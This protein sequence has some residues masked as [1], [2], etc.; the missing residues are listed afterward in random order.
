[1]SFA[2]NLKLLRTDAGLTQEELAKRIGVSQKTVS[3]W[4]TG[5][6]D[7]VM[8]DIV[9]ICKVLDCPMEKLSDTKTRDIGDVSFE[10]ILVRMRTLTISQLA[11]VLHYAAELSDQRLKLHEM[12]MMKDAYEKQI[13]EMRRKI[14]SP[15]IDDLP[16][17]EP[18]E[19]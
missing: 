11:E 15:D 13:A 7:P 3:S 16:E 17:A 8:K 14:E 12:E 5:R 10:D 18:H 2:R 19:D 4:E 9:N 6:T 1:M